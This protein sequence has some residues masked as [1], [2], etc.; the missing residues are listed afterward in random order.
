MER[1]EV[2]DRVAEAIFVR[3]AASPV[4]QNVKGARELAEAAYQA[5]NAFW[6]ERESRRGEFETAVISEQGVAPAGHDFQ[7]AQGDPNTC[8]VCT[9]HI[10]CHV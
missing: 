9:K 4:P 5:A 8:L 7:P 1:F 10:A 3:A 6:D 2:V